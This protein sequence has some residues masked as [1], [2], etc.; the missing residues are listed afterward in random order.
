MSALAP[1]ETFIDVIGS[2]SI[3][4]G[5][6]SL[7]LTAH[8]T[9]NQLGDGEAYIDGTVTTNGGAVI[10]TGFGPEYAEV[11]TNVVTTNGGAVTLTTTADDAEIYPFGAMTTGGGNVTI[12]A[13]G[14]SYAEIDPE[15]IITAGGNITIAAS[16]NDVEIYPFGPIS[17]GAGAISI[18]ATGTDFAQT[19]FND[20]TRLALLEFDGGLI[21]TTTG[22][23]TFTATDPVG[24]TVQDPVHAAISLGG[25]IVTGTGN[26]TLL[27]NDA[28]VEFGG[29]IATAGGDIIATAGGLNSSM[30]VDCGCGT[31]FA[32]GAGELVLFVN[33]QGGT[34][35]IFD[36]LTITGPTSLVAQ[37]QIT[38]ASISDPPGL[39]SLS[40]YSDNP[41]SGGPIN[42]P[43]T[44]ASYGSFPGVG[45]PPPPPPLP[46]VMAILTTVPPQNPI[47]NPITLLPG[48][49]T[50]TV[51]FL[52]PP[53]NPPPVLDL[54]TSGTTTQ[55][56]T[57]VT[58]LDSGNQLFT[59]ISP[60]S[61]DDN[62][63]NPD[64]VT[65]VVPVTVAQQAQ[66]K[67]QVTETPL[68]GPG[69]HI[70]Q[71]HQTFVQHL[72]VPG[73]GQ[74][75]SMGGNRSLWFATLGGP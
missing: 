16:A 36:P 32:T 23:V 68:G 27:A 31:P 17:S 35:D 41:V 8:S 66:P 75:A 12:T 50:P 1:F 64:P 45:A 67:G 44:Q 40:F 62:T 22:N 43:F 42:M 56:L 2:V 26:V 57:S 9:D 33:G 51:T 5:S 29:T 4:P 48:I 69:S 46:V 58:Q 72:G 21:T 39:P 49:V 13:T 25:A 37:Q 52:P 18:T 71:A 55:T 15:A 10:V 24:F 54:G 30:V 53:S 34:L 73:I 3:G 65:V 59:Q 28:D 11:D 63:T 19:L 14:R 60:H 70:F 38:V 7:T 74:P 6:G 20:P 61:G 47:N